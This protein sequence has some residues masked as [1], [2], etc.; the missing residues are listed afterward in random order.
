ME[1]R[2]SLE[3][4]GKGE[5]KERF[6]TCAPGLGTAEAKVNIQRGVPYSK[7]MF[8]A[9]CLLMLLMLFK[10]MTVNSRTCKANLGGW[11]VGGVRGTLPAGV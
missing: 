1:P 7:C 4:G 11:F 6:L 8:S 3:K 2:A 10:R 9:Q 5:T